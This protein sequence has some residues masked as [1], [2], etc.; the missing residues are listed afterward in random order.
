MKARPLTI[1]A[2]IGLAAALLAAPARAQQDKSIFELAGGQAKQ[3]SKDFKPA[4]EKIETKFGTLE[5]TGGGFPTPETT[6]KAL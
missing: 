3:T 4:P 5:F 2:L 6:R 1:I